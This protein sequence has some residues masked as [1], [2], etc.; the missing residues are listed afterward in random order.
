MNRIRKGLVEVGVGVQE[1]PQVLEQGNVVVI[2][3]HKSIAMEEFLTSLG[4]SLR[5]KYVLLFS[6]DAPGDIALNS[7][8]IREFGAKGVHFFADTINLQAVTDVVLELAG[9]AAAQQGRARTLERLLRDA[10]DAAVNTTPV[11]RLKEEIGKL[12]RGITQVSERQ[13][14]DALSQPA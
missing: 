10:V 2:S 4:P 12:R 5:D 14:Q 1:R 13:A 7:R 3:G 6:C 8:L 9:K 11:K